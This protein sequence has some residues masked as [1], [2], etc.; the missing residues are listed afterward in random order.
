M[1]KVLSTLSCLNHPK[2]T[3]HPWVYLPA[4]LSLLLVFPR[5]H[6]AVRKILLYLY[7]L[8]FSVLQATPL[9]KTM[10]YYTGDKWCSPPTCSTSGMLGLMSSADSACC[11]VVGYI[12]CY[13]GHKY[14]L[15]TRVRLQHKADSRNC[16]LSGFLSLKGLPPQPS[17]APYPTGLVQ[18]DPS[19]TNHAGLW[20]EKHISYWSY[21]HEPKRLTGAAKSHRWGCHHEW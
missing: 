13:D 16:L 19:S 1:S 8:R 11:H 10:F 15:G 7:Y 2:Q 17:A 14:S 20:A 12:T 18:E 5:Q 21:L 9:Y 6:L 3:H 4:L